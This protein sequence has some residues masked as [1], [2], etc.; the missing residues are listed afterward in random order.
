MIYPELP[1]FNNYSLNISENQRKNSVILTPWYKKWW[2]IIFI[3]SSC[4]IIFFIILFLIMVWKFN[5]VSTNIKSSSTAIAQKNEIKNIKPDP[6]NKD[7]NIIMGDGHN[8]WIGTTSP[9]ITIVEFSDF[10]CPYCRQSFSAM[11]ELSLLYKN[12]I[13]II[14]RD[15]PIHDNSMALAMA[16]RCAGEQKKFWL[17]HDK[18]FQ[19]ADTLQV[20]QL[21]DVANDIGLD[22]NK[23]DDCQKTERYQ[24]SIQKDYSDG[25]YL[26]ISGTPTWFINGYKVEG[27]MTRDMLEKIIAGLLNKN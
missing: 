16:A 3:I 4:I 1:T 8:A 24:T 26:G 5:Q 25:E 23:F 9:Q 21:N 15:F 7:I 18:L 2:G 10:A 19:L 17:M 11:R 14:F 6:V 27:A 12:D 13:K 22:V 20:S